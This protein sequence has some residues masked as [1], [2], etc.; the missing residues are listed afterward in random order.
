MSKPIIT[1]MLAVTAGFVG[2]SV[3]QRIFEAPAV[4][5]QALTPAQQVRASRFSLVD[6]TGKVQGEFRLNG[7][8]PEIALYDEDGNI[9][10]RATTNHGLQPLAGDFVH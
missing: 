5:A 7:G 8:K 1:V 6:S 9:A 4:S 10:W 2:G 3:S